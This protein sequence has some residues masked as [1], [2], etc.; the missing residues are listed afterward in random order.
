MAID[1]RCDRSELGKMTTA[2]EFEHNDKSS[3]LLVILLA[4]EVFIV[5]LQDD[6]K[7][8]WY[9]W[10]RHPKTDASYFF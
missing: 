1:D 9:P 4:T 8:C 10:V 2:N 7:G 6:G 5:T 3:V